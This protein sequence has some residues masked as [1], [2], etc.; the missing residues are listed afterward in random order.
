MGKASK[1]ASAL[2]LE[3]LKKAKKKLFT[4]VYPQKRPEN[5]GF[6][7]KDLYFEP[8]VIKKQ[9]VIGFCIKP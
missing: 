3:A 4:V 2:I 1:L 9:S 6:Q 8:I 7:K 5:E